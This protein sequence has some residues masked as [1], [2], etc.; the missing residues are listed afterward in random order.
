M[1]SVR[2]DAGIIIKESIAAVLPEAAVVKAL[3]KKNFNKDVVIIAIGKAAWNMAKAAKDTLGEKVKKGIVVTK[4]KHSKG[5]I[6]NCEIIEAGHP[7]PD[8]N[9]M[10]GA[11]KA[12]ELVSGIPHG[13][14]ILFL[15]SLS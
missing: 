10:L 15:I 6:S 9:S 3:N 1:N 8:S 2:D 13:T 11:A 5:Y 12:L 7:L 14:E 4:Y